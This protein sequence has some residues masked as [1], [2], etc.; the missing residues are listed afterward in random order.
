MKIKAATSNTFGRS[1]EQE[2]ALTLLEGAVRSQGGILM[3]E[4][5]PGVGKTHLLRWWRHAAERAGLRVVFASVR[6]LDKDRPFRL[7][8]GAVDVTPVSA[9]PHRATIRARVP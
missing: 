7:L 8:V 9:D 2:V 6:E 4:G 1:S 3:V 5:E